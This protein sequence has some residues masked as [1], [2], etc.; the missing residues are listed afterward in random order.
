MFETRGEVLEMSMPRK[1]GIEK[2]IVE[3]W[4]SFVKNLEKGLDMLEEDIEEAA[5]MADSCTAEWC[6][7]TEHVIDELSNSLF[8][9]SEP[10]W[11]SPE[12]SNKIKALK[13]RVHDLYARY[14]SVRK[15]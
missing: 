10:T 13:R 1:D 3:G 4:R 8:S 2:E 6:Q 15:G 9:I 11:S 12:D 14:K 7:A 5:K